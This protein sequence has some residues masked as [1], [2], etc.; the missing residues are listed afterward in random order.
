MQ[1][2]TRTN[3]YDCQFRV[4]F[5][6]NHCQ[7]IFKTANDRQQMQQNVQQL[8]YQKQIPIECLIVTDTY[9]DLTF[10]LTPQQT[11][12]NI[13][14]M[15]KGNLS[16]AWKKQHVNSP[17]QLWENYYLLMTCN[18]ENSSQIVEEYLKKS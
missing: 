13:I 15:L 16:R 10:D 12:S 2:K 1:I 14:K 5:K 4:I 8:L 9:L 7:A 17:K 6:T 18:N 11:P 3:T